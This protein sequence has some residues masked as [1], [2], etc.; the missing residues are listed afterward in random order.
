MSAKLY[1]ILFLCALL[2][3]SLCNGQESNGI[4][5]RPARQLD[6][7]GGYGVVGTPHIGLRY[8]I[9]DAVSFEC[10]YG[11]FFL[12]SKNIFCGMLNYYVAPSRD[13][14]PMFSIQYASAHTKLFLTNKEYTFYLLTINLGL[15]IYSDS[16]IRYF[17][18]FGV[19]K[20][21][22]N[23]SILKVK[24]NFDFGLSYPVI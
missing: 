8:A 3:Y 17:L 4:S 23:E 14:T 9:V 7:V 5:I 22:G 12:I 13:I 16:G 15:D 2:S 18:R 20:Q 21:Y 10:S 1:F 6:V 19:I 11:V 24:G